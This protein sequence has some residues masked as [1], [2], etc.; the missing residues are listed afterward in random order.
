[1][2]PGGSAGRQCGGGG[3]GLQCRVP[4]LAD[5]IF[6]SGKGRRGRSVGGGSLAGRDNGGRVWGGEVVRGCS[7]GGD[8][9]G[10][11]A[12]VWEVGGGFFILV[13]CFGWG[14]GCKYP[15]KK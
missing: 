10:G 13:E 15:G 5:G 6:D 9:G 4:T 1:M 2:V 7:A 12:G 14:W 11:G 8:F 3:A